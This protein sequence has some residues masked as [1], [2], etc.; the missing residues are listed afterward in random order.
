[1]KL[2]ACVVLYEKNE[3]ILNN[4]NTYLPFCESVV[5]VDNGNN[6]VEG[7]GI[8]YISMGGNC[9]VAA[10]LNRGLKTLEELGCDVALTM[11]DDSC[12]PLELAEEILPVVEEELKTHSIVGMNFN[13]FPEIRGKVVN[14]TK[15]WLTSGNFVKI[16]AWRAAG[17]Y[18]EELFIDYVDFEFCF[19]AGR[20]CYLRDYSISHKIGN[21]IEF[22]L[23]GKSFHAMNHSPLRDYYRFRN[24]R[25]LAKKYM[26]AFA[27]E[28]AK[29]LFWQLPKMLIF[30]KNRRE[31]LKMIKR[32]LKDAGKGRLGK[33]E[34]E[35]S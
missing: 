25:Y 11:D 35:I 33:Y 8:V 1:M 12:F 20:V 19:R 21:P 16:D 34:E 29:E 28:Y 13:Y 23:F 6:P 32:G 26:G 5:A 24:S 14:K 30:E 22:R 15:F 27:A 18:K 7:E 31:K 2:G 10:A 17:G 9:G 3:K 4:I